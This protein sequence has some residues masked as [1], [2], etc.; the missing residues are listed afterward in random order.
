M[1]AYLE[2]KLS[3]HQYIS[4]KKHYG[5]FKENSQISSSWHS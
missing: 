1:S 4:D 5:L 2:A 3:K